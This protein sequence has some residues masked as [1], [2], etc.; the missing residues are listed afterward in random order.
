MLE[1][2][3]WKFRIP[4]TWNNRALQGL[5]SLFFQ[6]VQELVPSSTSKSQIMSE[7]S[8]QRHVASKIE[9]VKEKGA[10][11]PPG[12][13]HMVSDVAPLGALSTRAAT[14]V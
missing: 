8:R 13:P 10:F 11:E 5:S 2:P 3:F 9:I 4:A 7:L 6:Q 14:E 12:S 1:S